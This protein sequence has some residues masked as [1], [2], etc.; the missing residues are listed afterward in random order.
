MMALLARGV[1]HEDPLHAQYVSAFVFPSI[2]L[3][4]HTRYGAHVQ[5]NL[6]WLAAAA[7]GKEK[8]SFRSDY[9]C[10]C[11]RQLSSM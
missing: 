8:V 5:S 1:P 9:H 10:G 7:D 11:V 3:I 2:K 6:A 4:G